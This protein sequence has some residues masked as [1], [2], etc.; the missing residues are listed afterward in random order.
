V[1]A[2]PV[3]NGGPDT[4]WREL[5]RDFVANSGEAC[6]GVSGRF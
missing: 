1:E 3:L 6:H 4:P 5:F 2:P